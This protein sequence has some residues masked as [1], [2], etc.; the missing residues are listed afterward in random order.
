V[1]HHR[2][3]A[4]NTRKLGLK[5]ARDAVDYDLESTSQ[6]QRRYGDLTIKHSWLVVEPYPSE[7]YESQWEG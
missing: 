4:S 1:V 7:E 3:V 2:H 5:T 6:S